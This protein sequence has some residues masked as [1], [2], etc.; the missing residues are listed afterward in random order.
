MYRILRWL[1]IIVA[2]YTLAIAALLG[3]QCM[4][5]YIAGNSPANIGENGVHITPVYTV[6]KV[7]AAL[8]PVAPAALGYAVLVVAALA[9]KALAEDERKV[10]MPAAPEQY[11]RM[12]KA[13]VEV[14]PVEAAAEERHRR[15]I[16]AGAY[17]FV[18][19]CAICSCLYLFNGRN[20]VSWDLEQ[21]MG[22]MLL[23]VAPWVAAAF[24]ALL[25]A[26]FG[27]ARSVEKEIAVLKKAKKTAKRP[28]PAACRVPV[29]A[30]RTVLYAAALVLIIWGVLNGGMRDV[31]VKAINICTEC[32]GLG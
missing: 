10:R 18:V 6:D 27:C 20:F 28:S 21:V 9:V 14:L 30:V 29:S 13:R 23:H 3:A 24:A 31:L 16:H 17:A 12:L 25:A 5:L 32:I 8:R 19:V 2:I 22:R 1:R 4:R 7:C 11:L 15:R 26:S